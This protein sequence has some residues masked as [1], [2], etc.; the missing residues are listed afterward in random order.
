MILAGQ[1]LLA[2]ATGRNRDL[3]TRELAF[4]TDERVYRVEVSG[5]QLEVARAPGTG[6]AIGAAAFGAIA[7]VGAIG[8]LISGLGSDVQGAAETVASEGARPGRSAD[9]RDRRSPAGDRSD[10]GRHGPP[11]SRRS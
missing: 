10:G 9:A 3:L 5:T 6:A 11:G 8:Q 4:Q 1:A 2:D 7:T